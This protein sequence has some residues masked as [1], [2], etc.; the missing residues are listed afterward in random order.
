MIK[1]FDNEADCEKGNVS[2]LKSGQR[3]LQSHVSYEDLSI[4]VFDRQGKNITQ[5]DLRLKLDRINAEKKHV[6]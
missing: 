5:H 1:Y 6:E 2:E 3:G 4:S